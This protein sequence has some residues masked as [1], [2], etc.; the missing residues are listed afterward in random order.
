MEAQVKELGIPFEKSLSL[1]YKYANTVAAMSPLILHELITSG[2]LKRGDLVMMHA[3]GAGA[4]S[5]E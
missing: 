1:F 3:H 4:S 5:G 2:R